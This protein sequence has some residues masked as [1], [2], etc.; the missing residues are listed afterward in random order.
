MEGLIFSDYACRVLTLDRT[1]I[2]I[3]TC[4]PWHVSRAIDAR[5]EACT[6][7]ESTT[8]RV[9]SAPAKGKKEVHLN[10][11]LDH[12]HSLVTN[13]S[14]V[15]FVQLPRL[16]SD[17]KAML[18]PPRRFLIS[19]SPSSRPRTYY[20]SISRFI[21]RARLYIDL[22][23]PRDRNDG[24]RRIA[25]SWCCARWI[26]SPLKSPP[27]RS[28]E[29]VVGRGRGQGENG[30]KDIRGLTYGWRNCRRGGGNNIYRRLG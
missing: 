16:E 26:C 27:R 28:G 11:W 22:D 1:S 6:T 30:E 25:K 3:A 24:R 19:N 5:P 13:H 2:E 29:Q 8:L 23:F 14:N 15:Q 17:L 18:I 21:Q 10:N 4:N 20:S 12:L 7:L 9:F